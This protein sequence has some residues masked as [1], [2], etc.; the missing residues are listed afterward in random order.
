LTRDLDEPGDRAAQIDEE[1]GPV[2]TQYHARRDG[3]AC[4]AC[5]CCCPFFVGGFTALLQGTPLAAIGLAHVPMM[6]R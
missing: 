4:E 3:P 2:M 5:L 1:T 6:P